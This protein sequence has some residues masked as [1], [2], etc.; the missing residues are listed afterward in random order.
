MTDTAWLVVAANWFWEQQGLQYDAARWLVQLLPHRH[1]LAS[2]LRLALWIIMNASSSHIPDEFQPVYRDTDE[3]MGL[4]EDC[5]DKPCCSRLPWCFLAGNYADFAEISAIWERVDCLST[6]AR[7][8]PGLGPEFC[9]LT[10]CDFM[11]GMELFR[12]ADRSG[13]SKGNLRGQRRWPG[14]V[15][16]SFWR[17]VTVTNGLAVSDVLGH[18]ALL[19]GDLGQAYKLCRSSDHCGDCQLP[20]N[21]VL[22]AAALW[23]RCTCI[24]ATC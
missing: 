21:A 11:L 10:D 22:L 2:D 9:L 12:Y 3:I 14:R 5:S 18:L 7:E 15:S 8:A 19:Q 17:A 6:G 4:L 1:T 23:S 13:R 16:I 24:T 20:G